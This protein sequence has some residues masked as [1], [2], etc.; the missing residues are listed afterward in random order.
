MTSPKQDYAKLTAP[1][2]L[3]GQVEYSR[4]PLYVGTQVDWNPPCLEGLPRI[5]PRDGSSKGVRVSP[6]FRVSLKARQ[7]LCKQKRTT[8]ALGCRSPF[9]SCYVQS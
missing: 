7:V 8:E 9:L 6:E 5:A 3:I 1:V 2:T 4:S